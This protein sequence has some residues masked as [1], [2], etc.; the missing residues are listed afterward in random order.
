M[1]WDR[2][3]K[4]LPLFSLSYG[5]SAYLEVPI[6]GQDTW[7]HSQV[8][9]LGPE[10]QRM[11]VLVGFPAQGAVGFSAGFLCPTPTLTSSSH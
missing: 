11:C 4:I 5:P 3:R 10:S 7:T 1:T 6:W 9:K 8:G 2:K